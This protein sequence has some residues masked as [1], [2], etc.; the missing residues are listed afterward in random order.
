MWLRKTFLVKE[1]DN[2]IRISR[3]YTIFAFF[4]VGVNFLFGLLTMLSPKATPPVE[5]VCPTG[6]IFNFTEATVCYE[7][8]SSETKNGA[9]YYVSW[10]AISDLSTTMA[11]VLVFSNLST[12]QAYLRKVDVV[13]IFLIIMG[14]IFVALHP[15]EEYILFV[16]AVMVLLGASAIFKAKRVLID[17]YA[18]LELKKHILSMT[19][20]T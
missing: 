5:T 14:Y 10:L 2:N 19:V 13:S 20:M 3:F 7:D 16:Y 1:G 15:N 9:L 18:P 4:F 17:N 8:E 11:V 12:N 6:T